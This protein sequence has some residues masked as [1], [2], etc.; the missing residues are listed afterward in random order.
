MEKREYRYLKAPHWFSFLGQPPFLMPH[1]PW[2]RLH[3]ISKMT[4]AQY[5]DWKNK[6]SGCDGRATIGYTCPAPKEWEDTGFTKVTQPFV[7]DWDEDCPPDINREYKEIIPFPNLFNPDG[8]TNMAIILP[9]TGLTHSDGSPVLLKPE[10]KY[11]ILAEQL[12][13]PYRQ[14]GE[15]TNRLADII[16]EVKSNT[17]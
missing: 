2:L 11:P 7:L 15:S 8:G 5:I 17:K 14:D 16:H 6:Q 4:T 12:N 3:K 13:E 10:F 1:K 9:S